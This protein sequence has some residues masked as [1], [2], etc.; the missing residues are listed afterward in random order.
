MTHA[1]DL[2]VSVCAG[3]GAE[4]DAATNA[5]DTTRIKPGDVS[6]CLYCGHVAVMGW[7]QKLRPMTDDEMYAIA[8]DP[9][10]LKVQEVRADFMKKMKKQ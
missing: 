5:T 6:V 3:C 10:V 9:R 2:P 4:N 8:G 1:Q 7:D